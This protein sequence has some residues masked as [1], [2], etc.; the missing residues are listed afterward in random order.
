MTAQYTRM[1]EIASYGVKMRVRCD[2]PRRGKNHLPVERRSRPS[3]AFVLRAR[4]ALIRRS[5]SG[6]FGA[7]WV[8]REMDRTEWGRRAN[9]IDLIHTY[10]HT[11]HSGTDIDAVK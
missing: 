11:V 7:C 4:F 9:D 3:R 5:L 8:M 6:V 1:R 10:S 2:A